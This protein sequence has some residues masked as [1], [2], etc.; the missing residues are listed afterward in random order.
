MVLFFA[1]FLLEEAEAQNF[2]EK[3]LREVLDQ[4]E[5]QF[6]VR[7]SYMDQTID[8]IQVQMPMY[9]LD[10]NQTL[11]H[12]EGQAAIDFIKLDENFISIRRRTTIV[13]ICGYLLD[14]DDGSA[15]S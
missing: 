9:D 3:A 8:N 11:D 7:F 14:K 2:G 13:K 4:L 12:L 10:L 1:V 15:V 5:E 6:S